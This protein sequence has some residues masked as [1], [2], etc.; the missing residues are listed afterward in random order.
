MNYTFEPISPCD[1]KEI[2]DIF[3]YYVDNSYAAY[4]EQKVPYDFFYML[5]KVS[6]GYPAVTIRNDQNEIMGFGMLRPY[7]PISTF[8]LTAEITY[9]LKPGFTRKG[10]GKILLDYL[11]KKAK[12]RG[13][14]SILASVSS[15]NNDSIQFHL[16][17]GFIE[18]GRF[19][20]IG[21]K[22][23]VPF[24]VVYFQRKL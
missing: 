8:A 24:D 14:T 17:S 19:S 3:N 5:L 7:S 21:R 20:E 10:V 4:P 11:L 22:K 6:Q 1:E 23:D 18:C 16:K 12:E 2:V 15:L 13:I 9:F